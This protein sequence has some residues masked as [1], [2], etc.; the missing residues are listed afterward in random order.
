M[1]GIQKFSKFGSGL[2][3]SPKLTSEPLY[4]A[5]SFQMLILFFFWF[6]SRHIIPTNKAENRKNKTFLSTSSKIYRLKYLDISAKNRFS[7][8][9]F[10]FSTLQQLMKSGTAYL[11]SFGESTPPFKNRPSF[12]WLALLCL[13]FWAKQNAQLL[14]TK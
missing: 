2:I 3:E 1:I 6:I 8:C 12:S 14:T 9:I 4:L 5:F 13:N 11:L 10:M 7:W